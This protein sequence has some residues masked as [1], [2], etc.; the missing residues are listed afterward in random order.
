MSPPEAILTAEDGAAETRLQSYERLKLALGAQVRLLRESL[1]GRGD[2][3]RA[4]RCDA[5]MTK[6]A[7]DRFTLAVLGQFKRGKSSLMNAVIGREILPVGLLP[8]TSAI[9]VLRFGPSERL[10]VRHAH[11]AFLEEAPLEELPNFV[12][13]KGNP[14]NRRQVQAA[15]L[16][17]PLPFLRHGLEFV[18]TPGIGSAISAN[19]ATTHA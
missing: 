8:L 2:A 14:G 10:L 9:T 17:L 4:E 13:E 18:D 7:E 3:Q 15:Y 16:E 5:L 11:W 6:L 19:T 1:K 12:T